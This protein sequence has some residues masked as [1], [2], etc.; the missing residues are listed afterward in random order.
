MLSTQTTFTEAGSARI[1]PNAV[2]Q[3]TEALT[4]ARLDGLAVQAFTLAGVTDWLAVPP[5]AMVDERPVARLHQALRKL[6]APEQAERVLTEAGRLTADYILTHRIP[7]AA[8]ALLKRAPAWLAARLLVP[9]IEAHAWT[10][11]GSGRFTGRAGP[12]T[13]FEL[14]GNPFC[15]S[16]QSPIPVCAWHEAVFQRLFQVLVSPRSLAVETGCTACGD[17]CCRFV[18]DWRSSGAC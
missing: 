1:G 7:R 13:V 6:A 10:F 14:T 9:A 8:Q 18:L 2:L 15:A 16:E 3:L 4:R 17:P 12:P 5:S 11:A